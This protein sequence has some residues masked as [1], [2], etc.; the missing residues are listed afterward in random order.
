LPIED[1]AALAASVAQ[2]TD[3]TLALSAA[4][5]LA[6]TCSSQAISALRT[7]HGSSKGDLRSIGMLGLAA[8]GELSSLGQLRPL[9]DRLTEW[10]RLRMTA[11]D[12]RMGQ[13]E[14]L[15]QFEDMAV[16]S[17][18]PQ[19]SFVLTVLAQAAPGRARDA[20]ERLLRPPT[21]ADL[22]A[23]LD[24]TAD[25]APLLGPRSEVIEA[26]AAADPATRTAAA[27]WLAR[28]VSR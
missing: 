24:D 5:V 7:L 3:A 21:G 9:A 20:A 16:G 2:G 13:P 11:G 19:R 25:L 6:E 8:C 1:R 12:V 4:L 26:L 15:Q 23:T 27:L 28:A 14:A 17:P 10:D 22:R 18:S